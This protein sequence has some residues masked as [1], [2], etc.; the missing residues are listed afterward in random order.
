VKRQLVKDTV[1]EMYTVNIDD[2][3]AILFEHNQSF[4]RACESDLFLTRL[5]VVKTSGFIQEYNANDCWAGFVRHRCNDARS[6]AEVESL[7]SL[8]LRVAYGEGFVARDLA[9]MCGQTARNIDAWLHRNI[10][11]ARYPSMQIITLINV[12]LYLKL[13][14]CEFVL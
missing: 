5:Q 1:A 3:C 13:K 2:A 4:K 11:K 7:Q 10:D 9:K 6:V 12:S 8:T 14:L